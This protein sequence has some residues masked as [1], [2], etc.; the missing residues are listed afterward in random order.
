MQQPLTCPE[1]QPELLEGVL[2]LLRVQPAV[3]C[4]TTTRANSAREETDTH[5]GETDRMRA[6]TAAG[7]AWQ[8]RETRTVAV[9]V[10]KVFAELH[11]PLDLEMCHV[12]PAHAVGV[13]RDTFHGGR[14]AESLAEAADDGRHALLGRDAVGVGPGADGAVAAAGELLRRAVGGLGLGGGFVQFADA[15]VERH[16][17]R[18]VR[19]VPPRI[20][21]GEN[22]TLDLL[23]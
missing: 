1:V 8:A 21:A 2:Q 11:A 9:K 16:H 3:V 4:R 23:G 7:V 12:V 10:G 13:A 5:G 14:R 6:T 17:G 15:L 22:D 20:H 19:K 18:S